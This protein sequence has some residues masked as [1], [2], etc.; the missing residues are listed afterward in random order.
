M[1]KEQSVPYYKFCV[2]KK[3]LPNSYVPEFPKI[4]KEPRRR[5]HYTEKEW[6]EIYTFMRSNEWLKHKNPKT[7]EQRKFVRDYAIIFINTGLRPT[8]LRRV[9]WENVSVEQDEEKEPS[10]LAVQIKLDKTQ[11]KTRKPRTIIGRRGDVFNRIKDYSKFTKPRDFVFCDNDT[12]EPI[13]NERFYTDWRFL[14]RE[15]GYKKT[16]RD[17]GFCPLRHAYCTYRLQWGVDILI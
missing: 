4:E 7:E 10:K 13:F 6:K 5:E 9:K 17:Y 15:L 16:K 2:S 1:K 8:E 14:I 12:G 11:T 3:Y